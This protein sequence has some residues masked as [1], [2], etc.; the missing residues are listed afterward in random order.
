[1][2]P[3]FLLALFEHL[4]STRS[5]NPFSDCRC[6]KSRAPKSVG[7]SII[8]K[9][10][11]SHVPDD[12]IQLQY[13]IPKVYLK[14]TLVIYRSLCRQH[15]LHCMLTAPDRD[16]EMT[17]GGYNYDRVNRAENPPQQGRG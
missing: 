10:M 9:I 8:T 2:T 14:M 16:T 7:A 1:M 6:S 15:V 12:C 17:G 3:T 11:A 13:Q 4:Q 5:Q